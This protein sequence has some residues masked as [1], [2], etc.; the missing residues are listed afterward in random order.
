MKCPL[1]LIDCNSVVLET[2]KQDG[3][4]LRRRA[5]GHCG[6]NYFS[7]EV[8]D[9]TVIARRIRPDKIAAREAAKADREAGIHSMKNINL[10]ALKAW[11]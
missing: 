4:L 10:D 5:C 11:R 7:R 3:E 8:P 6:K 9:L 2:R 1:C